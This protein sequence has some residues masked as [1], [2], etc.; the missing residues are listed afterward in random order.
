MAKRCSR[1]IPTTRPI[2][3]VLTRSRRRPTSLSFRVCTHQPR[4]LISDSVPVQRPTLHSWWLH[5]TSSQG[6]PRPQLH[7]LSTLNRR[8]EPTTAQ[9]LGSSAFVSTAYRPPHI[10]IEDGCERASS[11]E[12]PCAARVPL[13]E[14]H[15]RASSH[16]PPT[17]VRKSPPHDT[18]PGPVMEAKA[19]DESHGLI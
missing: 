16:P 15:A 6:E 9:S 11:Q 2:R 7:G 12:E 17:L 18:T 3:T 19:H 4:H 10:L 1:T 8:P 13:V 5:G 14:Q